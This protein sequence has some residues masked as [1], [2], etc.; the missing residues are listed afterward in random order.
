M[1]HGYELA[2]KPAVAPDCPVTRS[3]ESVRVPRELHASTGDRQLIW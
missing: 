3:F 2:L 1:F